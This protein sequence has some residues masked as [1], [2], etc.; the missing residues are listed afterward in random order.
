MKLKTYLIE[1]VTGITVESTAFSMKEA[2]ILAT[3]EQIK[4]C[5]NHKIISVKEIIEY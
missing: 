2:V 4:L 3:A 5:N 1:F